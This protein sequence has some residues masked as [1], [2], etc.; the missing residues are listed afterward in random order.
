MFFVSFNTSCAQIAIYEHTY[1]SYPTRRSSFSY[2]FM[3]NIIPLEYVLFRETFI[4]RI[5][6]VKEYRVMDP[7]MKLLEGIVV[8]IVVGG[9]L[10]SITPAIVL[11]IIW[12]K[13]VKSKKSPKFG[14]SCLLC[15]YQ[16]AGMILESVKK[17]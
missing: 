7:G 6:M 17:R 4:R 16:D 3:G 14:P 2:A 5:I 11:D 8:F 10:V 9:F 12:Y 15:C 1:F 13:R